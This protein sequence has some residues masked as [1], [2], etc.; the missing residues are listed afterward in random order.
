MTQQHEDNLATE[1]LAGN[2]Y[3]LAMAPNEKYVGGDI[4]YNKIQKRNQK[5]K[6]VK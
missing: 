3:K 1:E 5:N 6:N 4:M 2:I